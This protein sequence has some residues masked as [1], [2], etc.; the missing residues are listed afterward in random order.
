MEGNKNIGVFKPYVDDDADN[1]SYSEH[2][3]NDEIHAECRMLG[4]DEL[5]I[6]KKIIRE[7]ETVIIEFEI[8]TANLKPYIRF[9]LYKHKNIDGL[10]FKRIKLEQGV[11]P[12]IDNAVYEGLYE[13][14]GNQYLFFKI[15]TKEH[16]VNLTTSKDDF[17]FLIVDDIVNTKKYYD[18]SLDIS[19]VNFFIKNDKFIFLVDE[20]NAIIETPI[21]GFRGEYYKMVGVLAG[22]GMV[23]SG[24]YASV[25]PFFYFGNFDRSLRYAVLTVDAKPAEIMGEKITIGDT[26][27]FTK[28]GIV[29]YALFLGNSKVLLNLPGDD[30]D[31][32]YISNK[33]AAD[34]K[35]IKDTMKLR[36]TGGKWTTHYDSIIQPQL[37]LFDRVLNIDRILE[38]Q[39][40]VKT[41]EQQIP[42]DYAYFNTHH[43]RKNADGLYN[44]TDATMI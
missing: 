22:L 19:V 12:K 11:I 9:K 18:F 35:F 31:D 25:G 33:F 4:D 1:T 28:G 21:S 10:G 38:P 43:I 5:D 30:E 44:V 32:S 17:Y 24:P 23:R 37:K 16:V 26:P 34:S 29:K 3:I 42:L 39:F 7:G 8:I 2:D 15:N 40:I 13:Y 14:D 41:F 20:N 27:L 6:R 36:D